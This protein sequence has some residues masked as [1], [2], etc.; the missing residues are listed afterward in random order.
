M[1]IRFIGWW[2][3]A[4][5]FVLVVAASGEQTDDN[6]QQPATTNVQQLM[7]DKLTHA[8][9]VLDGIVTEDYEKIAEHADMMR[10]I[11]RA[12][13]W[14]AVD[15]DAYRSYSD[16]FQRITSKLVEA[17]QKQKR[18]AITLQYLQLTIG[19]IECHQYIRDEET[20][21]IQ[22]DLEE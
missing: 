10:I 20:R 19:C 1:M 4:A 14:Q 5:V 6:Q 18:D 9:Y 13:S 3:A 2:L 8:Q 11:S 7:R 22:G 21:G 15:T 12:T 17:A 16:R